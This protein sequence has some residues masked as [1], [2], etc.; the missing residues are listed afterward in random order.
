MAAE[1][2]AELY[3]DSEVT[4]FPS[5]SLGLCYSTL[6]LIDPEGDKESIVA[7]FEETKERVTTA[8]VSPAIRD[9]A[10]EGVEIKDG[11]MMGIIGKEI[12]VSIPSRISA[13]V[14]TADAL[15]SREGVFM[16]TVF[17]GIDVDEEE[18]KTVEEKIKALHPQAEIYFTNGAQEVYPY[19]YVA[20]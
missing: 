7:T 14:A 6:A 11:D 18:V 5:K 19:L 13:A 16:L 3:T 4:V 1:Q 12:V 2:A 10:I 20:E 9:T 8:Y 17:Y 15:L